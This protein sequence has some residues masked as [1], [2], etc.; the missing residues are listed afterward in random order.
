MAT[1]RAEGGVATRQPVRHPVRWAALAVA[2]VIILPAVVVLGS[3]LG[4]DPRAIRSPLIDKPVPA[5]TLETLEG[6]T[7]RSSDLLG[8]PFVVNFWASW[9]VPCRSEHGAL[10]AF[11]TK[12]QPKGVEVLGVLI[13]DTP[14]GALAFRKELGGDWPILEES[15]KTT[16]DFGVT[17]PPET[18]VVDADGIVRV[19]YVGAITL[20][21]LEAAMRA[22]RAVP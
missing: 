22:I 7:I 5:F 11:Y 15:R 21:A 13:Q 12:Y 2:L 14:K 10:N 9:C 6:E 19:K 18:F 16:L 20:P 17:G 3:R 4:K 1:A 8:Q